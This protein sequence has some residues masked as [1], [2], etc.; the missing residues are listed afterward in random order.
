MGLDILE[1]VMAV[2]REFGIR[3]SD[4]ALRR[5][6]TVSQLHECVVHE[7]GVTSP[8]ERERTWRK[9]VDIIE[10]ETGVDRQRIVPSARFI[11][12]LDLS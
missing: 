6:E 3:L 2:E 9:L 7:L 11:H 5:A 12:D 4:E 8:V 1:L 10:M